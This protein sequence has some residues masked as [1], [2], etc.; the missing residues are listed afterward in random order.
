MIVVPSDQTIT[1]GE[2]IFL[3]CVMLSQH[4][5]GSTT[6]TWK[7]ERRVNGENVVEELKNTT[8]K[9]AIIQREEQRGSGGYILIRSTLHLGCVDEVDVGT[10]SCQVANAGAT[11][12][13]NFMIDIKGIYTHQLGINRTVGYPSNLLSLSPLFLFIFYSINTSS[14]WWT[15]R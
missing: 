6:V 15:S 5:D 9:V 3:P 7:R 1:K 10:Y 8:K 14:K 2:S 11:K 4:T 12:T 13:A